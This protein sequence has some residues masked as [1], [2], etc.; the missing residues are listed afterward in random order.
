MKIRFNV[1]TLHQTVTQIWFITFK[2]INWNRKEERHN[3]KQLIGLKIEQ[4]L[5]HTI[6]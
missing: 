4:E 6:N 3:V 5:V 1:V 2:T